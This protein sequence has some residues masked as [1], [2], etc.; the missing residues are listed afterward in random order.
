MPVTPSGLRYRVNY[1]LGRNSNPQKVPYSITI[2]SRDLFVDQMDE[3]LFELDKLG[4]RYGE[5]AENR[6]SLNMRLYPMHP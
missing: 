5:I 2:Y 4:M 1:Q 6:K 3:L